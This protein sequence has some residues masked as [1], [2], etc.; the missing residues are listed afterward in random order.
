MDSSLIARVSELAIVASLHQ[1]PLKRGVT[2]AGRQIPLASLPL[3][4]E[5]ALTGV[6][7]TQ[8]VLPRLQPFPSAASHGFHF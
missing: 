6:M 5:C 2:V 3:L 4:I 7:E 1:R 8:A